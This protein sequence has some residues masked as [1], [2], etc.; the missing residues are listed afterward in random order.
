MVVATESAEIF[1]RERI[2]I[3]SFKGHIELAEKA[4]SA[5]RFWKIIARHSRP[6]VFVKDYDRN[7]YT[8]LYDFLESEALVIR[9]LE[10][11]SPFSASLEGMASA[12]PDLIYAKE[13][14][15]RARD[16]WRNQQIGQAARNIRDIASASETINSPNT[17][18]GL[19]AYANHMLE[20]LL[21][22]Q[23]RLNESAGITVNR[24]DQV[25]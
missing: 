15:Q 6:M 17:P 25:V 22:N 23:Q 13:R 2:S 11:N 24:I 7:A 21:E 20:Q 9:R 14:E 8:P 4:E 12:L 10:I 18:L 1:P 3:S 5:D 19:Q 16:E